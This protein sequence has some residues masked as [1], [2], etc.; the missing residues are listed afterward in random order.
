MPNASPSTHVKTH[1]CNAS[2][3]CLHAQSNEQSPNPPNVTMRNAAR[4]SGCTS[5]P[6]YNAKPTSK[7]PLA[8]RHGAAQ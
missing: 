7:W 6:R 3:V 1:P 8:H 5:C 4:G 2:S